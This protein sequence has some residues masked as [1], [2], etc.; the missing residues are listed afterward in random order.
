MGTNLWPGVLLNHIG[1]VGPAEVVRPRSN[2]PDV[3]AQVLLVWCGGDG[4]WMVLVLPLYHTGD[5]QPLTG[6]VLEVVRP[7]EFQ[8]RNICKQ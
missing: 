7:L 2:S 3:K 6:L 1:V 8:V 5:T 4:E